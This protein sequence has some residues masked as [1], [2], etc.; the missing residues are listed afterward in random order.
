[1]NGERVVEKII[2]FMSAGVH[3]IDHDHLSFAV[4]DAIGF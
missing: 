2:L 3:L 1:M 4:S